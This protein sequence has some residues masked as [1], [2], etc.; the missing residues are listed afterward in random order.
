MNKLIKALL[1][2][3]RNRLSRSVESD[4]YVLSYPKSGRTWLRALIGKYLSR[5][6][7]LPE[8][9]ILS[10]EIVTKKSGL[11]RVSFDHDGS[12]LRDHIQYNKLCSRSRLL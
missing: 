9:R 11:P 12:A 10:T 6:H 2:I 3:R 8:H 4:I 7:N 1:H 5:K